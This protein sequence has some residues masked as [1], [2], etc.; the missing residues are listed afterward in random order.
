MNNLILP[1]SETILNRG[2][3]KYYP[4]YIEFLNELSLPQVLDLQ[5]RVV[6]TMTDPDMLESLS[7]QE[8]LTILQGGGVAAG[9][10][11]GDQLVAFLATLFPG[12]RKE[13][14]GHDIDLPEEA[15]PLVVH[16]ESSFVHPNYVGNNL[17]IRLSEI[18]LDKVKSF[19]SYRYLLGTVSPRNY[20]C[21][22]TVFAIPA[23]VIR[24]EWKY[25]N[26]LRFI[27]FQ[28]LVS[29]RVLD[30]DSERAVVMTDLKRQ[31][32]LMEQGYCGFRLDKGEGTPR[33]VYARERK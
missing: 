29:P 4:G 21:L 19:Q 26:R 25:Q 23:L 14:L 20:H 7:P 10:L 24:L 22:K 30:P 32:K 31:L 17:Q 1:T 13:N 15:L 12:K 3:G 9:M 6:G 33:I 16:F 2:E 18:V 27:F 8:F 11:V 5:E 28:D